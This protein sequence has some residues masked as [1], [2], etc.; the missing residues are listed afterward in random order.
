METKN[1]DIN[2]TLKC[3][4]CGAILHFAPGTTQLRCD[5]CGA[6]NDIAPTEPAEIRSF[7]YAEFIQSDGLPPAD[8]VE[9]DVVQCGNCGAHTTLPNGVTS[10]SCGFCGSPLVM[11]NAQHRQLL[12]PHYVLPFLFDSREAERRFHQWIGRLWFAP[13]ALIKNVK[14][15]RRDHFKGTYLPHW[16]YDTETT[17]AYNGQCGIYYYVSE[18][19]TTTENGRTVQRTRQ[20]RHT[21]WHSVSGRVHCSFKDVLVLASHSLS[22]KV[23]DRLEPWQLARMQPFD[24]RYLSGFRAE[25]YAVD[26]R[27]GLELAKQKMHPT[28][29]IA[30][31]RDIGG[32][33]Q[34]IE[35]QQS[36]YTDIRLKY[37]L[38]PIWIS[39]FTFKKKIYQIAV[40]ASTGEVIGERPY[41][42][43]KIILAVVGGIILV[44][45]VFLLLQG[46]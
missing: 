31:R 40:N 19:Y 14:Q 37:N 41:S 5:Y 28:I 42:V 45:I 3:R 12:K 38:L 32:D 22:R 15:I 46:I 26:A 9:A 21:R 1:A 23:A 39:A 8:T 16:A 7:D 27:A 24:E 25:T 29:V 2:D 11:A 20:V 13:N 34:H 17:T 10:D 43:A 36:D 18:S 44:V 30:I 6:A 4:S 33:E 35:Y